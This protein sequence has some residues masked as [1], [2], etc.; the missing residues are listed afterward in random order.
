MADPIHER[1]AEVLVDYST[2]VGK[3]DL[4][5]IESTPLAAP[6][7]RAV[8]RRV[9][10]AGGH[11]EVRL[12]LD[13]VAE[14]LLSA[15]NDAQLEW[16][17]PRLRG[18]SE[19]ADVRI[20]IEADTNTRGLTGIDPARQARFARAR[21]SLRDRTMERAARGELRRVVTAFPTHASAQDAEMSLAEY[22]DFVY[23]A[24]FLNEDDPVSAWGAL[25]ETLTRLADWLGT[26]R[27]LRVVTEGTDL[28]VGVEGRT[29][30]PCDGKE[31]FPDGEVFTGPVETSVEGHVRFSFPAPHAGRLVRDIELRFEGGEV[32]EATAA[33]G[34]AFLREML[35]MDEGSRRLGEFAFG[36]NEAVQEF[37]GHTLF[38]EKLGGTVHMA[39]GK[40]YPESGG[41]NESALHWDLV[42]DLRRESE[43]HA[44]G[45]LVY[46][47]GAFLPGLF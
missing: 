35:A 21:T 20:A 3:G 39:L 23:R 5:L 32:V 22:E 2:S 41:K 28:T 9:V 36:M 12:G 8:Y 16:T 33:E 7:I 15:G 37:T 13:G 31:N 34:E 46:R 26:K 11:P 24:G 25:G 17:S 14:A 45:E 30:I 19:Q 1:F 18:D 47:N 43:V 44:D 10:Q 27:E 4:V 42:C 38:D 29:W 40:A 6:L